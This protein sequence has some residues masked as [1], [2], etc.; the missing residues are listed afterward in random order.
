MQS[1]GE[2]IPNGAVVCIDLARYREIT[3][4]LANR[5]ALERR[6]WPLC[7]SKSMLSCGL[8]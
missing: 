7:R 5:T 3:E 8:P 1:N 6:L 2:V 4:S